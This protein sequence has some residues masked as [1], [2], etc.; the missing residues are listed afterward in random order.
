MT[1]D[2]TRD[3]TIEL[4]DDA[5]PDAE[6]E[7]LMALL[8]PDDGWGMRMGAITYA[9]LA[10]M[11]RSERPYTLTDLWD[12]FAD[13]ERRTSFVEDEVSGDDQEVIRP[14]LSIEDDALFDGLARRIGR[15]IERSENAGEID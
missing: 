3:T 11:A 10:V 13:R 9:I 12:V 15:A 5:V 2:L 8:I 6:I 4:A 14:Y 7:R 1:T